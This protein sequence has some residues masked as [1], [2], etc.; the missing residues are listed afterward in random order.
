[1]R[2]VGEGENE[3]RRVSLPAPSHHVKVSRRAHMENHFGRGAFQA[4]FKSPPK[5]PKSPL[6]R[7]ICA[8]VLCK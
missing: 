2:E 3:Q 5:L 8:L 4:R 1:M 6:V 7:E